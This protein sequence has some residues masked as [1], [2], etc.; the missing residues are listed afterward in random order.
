[1]RLK[2]QNSAKQVLDAELE[3]L[4]S[5]RASLSEEVTK[6]IQERNNVIADVVAEKEAQYASLRE[7]KEKC[8]SEKTSLKNEVASLTETR[9]LLLLPLTERE[10]RATKREKDAQEREDICSQKEHELSDLRSELTALR[11]DAID[12]LSLAKEKVESADY[13]LARVSEAEGMNRVATSEL[14]SKWQSF[15]EAQ[16]LHEADM[17]KKRD[18]LSLKEQTLEEGRKWSVS[19]RSRLSA[20]GRQIQSE[21]QTIESAFAEGRKKGYLK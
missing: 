16:A 7:T 1:M 17:Q 9:K 8:V 2:P 19:E 10:N 21:R 5:E 15:R 4:R 13:R 20:L 3:H 12:T 6:L 14:A 18:E 11:E